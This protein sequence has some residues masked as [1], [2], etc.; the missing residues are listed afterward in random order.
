MTTREGGVRG[1]ELELE[2]PWGRGG[3]DSALQAVRRRR[4]RRQGW[5]RETRNPGTVPEFLSSKSA[6]V[7]CAFLDTSKRE[8]YHQRRC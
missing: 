2:L 8:C 1:L 6:L 5:T 4:E 3:S 7:F